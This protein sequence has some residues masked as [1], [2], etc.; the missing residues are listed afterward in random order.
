LFLKY[1]TVWLVLLS[2]MLAYLA[3]LALGF[4]QQ[5]YRFGLGFELAKAKK[6]FLFGLPA[7]FLGAMGTIFTSVDKLMIMGML[8]RVMLGLYSFAVL[9][10]E[11]IAFIPANI[12]MIIL[13][14]Q[15]ERHSNG[16]GEKTKN[17]LFMPLL[18]ISYFLPLIIGSVYFFSAEIVNYIFPKYIP[19]LDAVYILLF[20]AFFISNLYVLEGYIISSNQEKRVLLPKA[21]FVIFGALLNFLAITFGFGLFGV[22]LATT[23]VYC[24]YFMFLLSY[25]FRQN[26]RQDYF[27][28]IA[29]ILFPLFFTGLLLFVDLDVSFFALMIKYAVFGILNIPLWLYANSRTGIIRLILDRIRFQ[30]RKF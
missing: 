20:G 26:F 10:L 7:T 29:T 13:P 14:S 27:R 12:A 18:L 30:I 17:M 19:A 28:R 21:G 9:V 22:A 23:S 25:T 11:M 8:N 1:L 24:M 2:A 16:S 6:L 5:R 4:T 3:S 15:L